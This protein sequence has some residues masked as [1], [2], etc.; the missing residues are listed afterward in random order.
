VQL[1]ILTSIILSTTGGNGP[2]VVPRKK[3]P[4][5]P[6]QPWFHADRS[7]ESGAC[8]SILFVAERF[9]H[10]QP[11]GAG[12]FQGGR[13]KIVAIIGRRSALADERSAKT[14][15]SRTMELLH[16]KTAQ[17]SSRP[18]KA[19]MNSRPAGTRPRS[20]CKT[21]SSAGALQCQDLLEPCAFWRSYRS[22]SFAHHRWTKELLSRFLK[23]LFSRFFRAQVSSRACLHAIEFLRARDSAAKRC[24]G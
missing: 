9:Q 5:V 10:L 13:S 12:V 7:I 19:R 18:T 14:R 15:S 20:P 1:R 24:G 3:S 11:G 8:L 6:C 16:P 21:L 23:Q 22:G 4:L 17:T 2:P